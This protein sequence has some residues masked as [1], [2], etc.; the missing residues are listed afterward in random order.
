MIFF[1]NRLT[2]LT[3]PTIV[4]RLGDFYYLGDFKKFLAMY[5]LKSSLNVG[6]FWNCTSLFH[7]GL[8]W[9][10]GDFFLQNYLFTLTPTTL[11]T[12][13]T[14]TTASRFLRLQSRHRS[15]WITFQFCCYCC[16]WCK[17]LRVMKL[18]SRGHGVIDLTTLTGS[19]QCFCLIINTATY[20]FVPHSYFS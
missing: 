19:V 6:N 18:F 20:H 14:F 10:M 7:L 2:M 1:A 3:T 4:T 11:I 16:W 17:I 15:C 5:L 8:P 12:I 9:R 13:T